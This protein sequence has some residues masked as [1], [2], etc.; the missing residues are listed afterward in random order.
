MNVDTAL[1]REILSR[2]KEYVR[3][4]SSEDLTLVAVAAAVNAGNLFTLHRLF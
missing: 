2:A 4:H 3:E 1:N